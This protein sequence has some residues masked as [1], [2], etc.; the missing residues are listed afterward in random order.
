MPLS[1]S[2][3]P[4]PPLAPHPPGALEELW[5]ARPDASLDDLEEAGEGQGGAA[6]KA[7]ELVPVALRYED[8]AQYQVRI[9][10]IDSHGDNILGAMP[11]KGHNHKS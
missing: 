11:A 9:V 4:W 3:P 10:A 2:D 5:K 7:A 8:A 1:T 6:G